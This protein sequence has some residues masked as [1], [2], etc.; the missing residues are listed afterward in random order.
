MNLTFVRPAALVAVILGAAALVACKRAKQTAPAAG[1]A[2]PDAPA[3]TVVVDAAPAAP[4]PDPPPPPPVDAMTTE[5]AALP[6]AFAAFDALMAAHM[7]LD[8]K[9]RAV[10]TCALVGMDKRAQLFAPAKLPRPPH[11]TEE[12]WT[13]ANDAFLDVDYRIGE[14]CLDADGKPDAG[15]DDDVLRLLQ[16]R[17]AA[18]A[19]LARRR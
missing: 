9:A 16:E 1:T 8:P 7:K 13:Q 5:A 3:A 4:A 10:A 2:T 6:P 17:Y 19:A 11:V 12:E 15:D 18:L 14:M